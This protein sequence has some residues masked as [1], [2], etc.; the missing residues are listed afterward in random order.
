MVGIDGED[1]KWN[2]KEQ[3]INKIKAAENY[4][5]ITVVTPIKTWVTNKKRSESERC[6]SR[7]FVTT[8]SSSTVIKVFPPSDSRTS[9][10]SS[11]SSASEFSL[12][13]GSDKFRTFKKKRPWSVLKIYHT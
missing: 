5:R 13:S 7:E 3:V 1:V 12:S 2:T 10:Y 6:N 4:L 9:P 8:S 11:M